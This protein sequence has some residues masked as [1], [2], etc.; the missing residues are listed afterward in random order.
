[1]STRS[2]SM[3]SV[4]AFPGSREMRS[5]LPPQPQFHTVEQA[6]QSEF[7]L[8]L[9]GPRRQLVGQLDQMRVLPGRQR[10]VEVAQRQALRCAKASGAVIVHRF[11]QN[12]GKHLMGQRRVD[13]SRQGLVE[14]P[15]TQ[16]AEGQLPAP[17]RI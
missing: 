1:M 9:G 8:L 12:R 3:G 14:S 15:L 4:S 6:L 11:L 2:W 13:V 5:A 10:A 7:E 16:N 17:E